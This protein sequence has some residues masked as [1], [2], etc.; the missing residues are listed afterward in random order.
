M[1]AGRLLQAPYEKSQNLTA[2]Q[3]WSN[4]IIE[5]HTNFSKSLPPVS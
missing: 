5:T 3:D 2:R 1:M 4:L